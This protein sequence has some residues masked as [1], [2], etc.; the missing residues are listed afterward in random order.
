M[1]ISTY[2]PKDVV[3]SI[4]AMHTVTGYADGT[5]IKIRKEMKPFEKT[6][7]MDGE[8]SRIYSQDDVYTVE[9]SLMQSSPS[10]DVLSMLYNVD[11]ATRMGKFP[12]GIRDFKGRTTFAAATAWIE[13]IPDVTYSNNLEVWTWKFGCSDVFLAIGGAGDSSVIEDSLLYGTAALP[14]LKDYLP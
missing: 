9:L 7:A 1:A 2:S 4:A 8:I 6:R 13:Q 5:F 12:I 3:I 11:V 14:I 10:H